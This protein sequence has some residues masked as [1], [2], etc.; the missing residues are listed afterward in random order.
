MAASNHP[1]FL[2]NLLIASGARRAWT[3][4]PV[5]GDDRTAMM[6]SSRRWGSRVGSCTPI[7]CPRKFAL[8]TQKRRP[9]GWRLELPA[10]ERGS[11][12]LGGVVALHHL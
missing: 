8:G 9:S 1:I 3:S 4:V 2:F 11:D 10:L 12:A 6:V 5:V 7:L